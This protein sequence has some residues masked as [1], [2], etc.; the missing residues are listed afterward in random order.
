[1]LETPPAPA[2]ERAGARVVVLLLLGLAVLA[3]GAYALAHEMTGDKVPRGTTVSGVRIGSHPQA[4]AAAVLERGLA[5]R[6]LAPIPVTVG[7]QSRTVTPAEAGLGVDYDASVAEAGGGDSWAPA[8]L[9]DYFTG[10]DE[11]EAVVT[12]DETAMT[13]LVETLNAEMGTQP[14]EGTVRFR[15]AEVRTRQPRVGSGLDP[16]AVREALTGAYLDDGGT[17]ELELVDVPPDIDEADVQ[18]ALTTFANPAVSE[19]VTLTFDDSVVKLAP[20]DYTAALSLAPADGVL[21]PQLDAARLAE[22]VKSR[23]GEA[24]APVDATVALVG[25]RPKVIPAKPGVTFDQAQID[26]A[27]LGLV[28]APSGQRSL[29]VT[30]TVAKPDFTT[31]DARRLNIKERI[32][33][34]TTYY[35]YAEYRNI[36]IGRAAELVN[37]TVLKPGETFSLNDTVGERTVANGFTKGFVISDGIFKEDLGGGVSQMATTTFNAMFFA[38]LKDIEHKPH[39]FYID[40]YPV[41]REATVVWGSV[42]LRFQ[43]DTPH[44]VLIYANVTPA[45]PSSS[46]VVTVSMYSTKTWDITTSTSDRYNLTPA[47]TRTLTTEDCYPNTGYGGFEVDVKRYFRR[48]GQSELHHSE[49]FHTTYTPSDTVICKPPPETPPA[50]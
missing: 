28:A 1:M 40:R 2:K 8:R 49:N 41:G 26:S 48:P 46:G 23:V 20:R 9:W 45:T 5:D 17:A 39:S 36:N 4:E 7:G 14:R 11:L 12:V 30:A 34:F 32:S 50:G 47:K 15:E 13:A 19:P 33:T 35:P 24:D 6:A 25:G 18:Q 38:G 42:D 3:G 16:A 29:A 44:G 22:L 27:F 10:G 43:N 37:G 21:V 31:G